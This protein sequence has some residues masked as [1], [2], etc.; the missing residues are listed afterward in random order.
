MT[1]FHDEPP[2]PSISYWS[3]NI[4]AEQVYGIHNP[5]SK[6]QYIGYY[7]GIAGIIGTSAIIR[8]LS[9]AML[10][11]SASK[12]LHQR[13]TNN[14]MKKNMV[15]KYIPIVVSHIIVDA[16]VSQIIRCH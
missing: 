1:Q 16:Y 11:V 10:G 6:A 12:T 9:I 14:I 8:S 5:Y 4:S 3:N 2:S 15:R 13:L 7:A